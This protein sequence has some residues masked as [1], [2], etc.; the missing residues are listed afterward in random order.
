MPDGPW[1]RRRTIRRRAHANLL[2]ALMQEAA[3][4][5]GRLLV[6]PRGADAVL[7]GFL[8]VHTL[9]RRRGVYGLATRDLVVAIVCPDGWPFERAAALQALVLEPAD[10][11]HPNS[12]GRWICVDLAGIAP[13]RLPETIYDV[14]RLRRT[15][16]DHV[17]DAEAAAF[18][19]GRIDEMPADPRPLGPPA[20]FPG[21]VAAAPA[22]PVAAR[23][24]ADPALDTMADRLAVALPCTDVSLGILAPALPPLDGRAFLRL[25]RRAGPPI[26]GAR[27][28]FLLRA[29]ARLR[30]CAAGWSDGPGIAVDPVGVESETLRR[31]VIALHHGL[32]ALGDPVVA[33][34]YLELCPP[35]P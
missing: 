13:A 21:A 18:V 19:R 32:E 31:E 25:A 22:G 7:L 9:V 8:D 20:S 4:S 2:V 5:S 1:E 29:Q 26:D 16:L 10:W 35:E 17:L 33:R 14:I 28:A 23:T 27:A 34:S 12:D 30:A 3:R 11:A 15:R 24:V 6:E